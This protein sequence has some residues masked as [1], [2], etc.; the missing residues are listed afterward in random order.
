MV[1]N[2]HDKAWAYLRLLT[3]GSAKCLKSDG[4]NQVPRYFFAHASPGLQAKTYPMILLIVF[5][6][7]AHLIG[8]YGEKRVIGYQWAFFFSLFFTPLIGFAV[9][10]DHYKLQ[11]AA[12]VKKPGKTAYVWAII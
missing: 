8:L 9:T 11:D 1:N 4:L 12:K 5:L 2:A 7:L 3:A 10:S 6:V